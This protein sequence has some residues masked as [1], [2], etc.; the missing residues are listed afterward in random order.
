MGAANDGGF[1]LDCAR[2]VR[3][4]GNWLDGRGALYRQLAAALQAVIERGELPAQTRLPP[5]RLLARALAVSRSTV[6]AAYTLLRED[7]WLESRQGSGSYVRRARTP[8]GGAIDHPRL[9]GMGKNAIFRG[10]I[11][12]PATTI[13][14][15]VAAPAAASFVATAISALAT[16][17]P[18]E[19]LEGH[20]YAPAGLPEL[21][22]AIAAHCREA[23]LPTAPEQILVTT[24]VQQALTL[25]CALYLQPGDTALVET[26]T[27]PGALEALRA[28]GAHLQCV[29]LDDGGPRLDVL[30]ELLGRGA[31][32][33]VYLT[34]TFNNPTG[35]V[36]SHLRRRRLAQ[37]ARQYQAPLIEDG[38]LDALNFTEEQHA[39]VAS[40]DAESPVIS[41]G[42]VSKTFWGG[43]RT[44]WIRA[45]QHV[46]A[47]LV[48]LKAVADLGGPVLSQVLVARLLPLTADASA[49]RR[50]E[51]LPKL[52]R[53][54]TALG[55][56][57]P[58]WH[59]RRPAGG[60]SLWIRLPQGDATEFAAVAARYGVTVV[61]GPAFAADGSQ[62]NHLR[63]PFVLPED[64]L[65][66]GVQRLA[67]A[68]QAYVPAGAFAPAVRAI[69]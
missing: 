55:A 69:V 59:W 22:E 54:A 38:V 57:L 56:L 10:L 58:E 36:M 45:P 44:G 63:L 64:V 62:R 21:R 26:P 67:A 52:Q 37:L 13:D 1:V 23:G 47:R 35:A 42:S 40:F 65:E 41:I 28:A 32:R 51:L 11:E 24:G 34:P 39:P 48:G 43:L 60:L 66:E 7:G 17:L 5:E 9:V 29:P 2:A 61:A 14:F 20:G 53:L 50:A 25:L 68:W 18:A 15:S 31:A 27:Y 3:L 33:L 8:A 30:E 19:L 49:E 4:L 46:I 12:T 16:D 6:V